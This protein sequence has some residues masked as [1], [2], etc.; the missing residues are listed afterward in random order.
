MAL[1]RDGI[2]KSCGIQDDEGLQVAENS[3]CRHLSWGA[4]HFLWVRVVLRLKHSM[5]E[6]PTVSRVAGERLDSW[7]EISAYL[8]RDPRTLQRWEKN[9]D[10]PVHRHVHDSQVSVYAY[11]HELDAWLASRTVSN[12]KGVPSQTWYARPRNWAVATAVAALV[13]A[14]FSIL[15]T[16]P[17]PVPRAGRAFRQLQ[18]NAEVDYTSSVSPDGRYLSFTDHR[19]GALG[20]RDLVSGTNR[21][22]SRKASDPSYSAFDAVFSPDGKSIIYSWIAASRPWEVH[23][24]NLDGTGERIVTK[25]RGKVQLLDWS[26]DGKYVAIIADQQLGLMSTSNGAIRI[27]KRLGA[28]AVQRAA[29]SRDGTYLVYDAPSAMRSDSDIFL[30]S[31]DGR[32]DR[33]LIQTPANEFMVGWDPKGDHIVFG[34]DR[35]GTAGIWRT[36]FRNGRTQGEPELLQ[37]DVGRVLPISVTQSGSVMLLRF[38]E[39]ADV[40][41]SQIGSSEAPKPLPGDVIGLRSS[42]SYSPDGRKLLYESSRDRTVRVRALDSNAEQTI[43]PKLKFFQKPRWAGGGKAIEISGTDGR[44]Q[45]SWRVADTGEVTL[46]EAGRPKPVYTPSEGQLGPGDATPSPDKS[47]VAVA[48]RGYPKAYNSLLLVPS[49][50]GDP[51]ELVRIKQP[52]RFTASFAWSPD[53]NFLYF[54]RH[55]DAGTE[56]MRISVRGGPPEPI[57]L[58]MPMIRNLSIHPDG[59]HIVFEAGESNATE[60][61]A[62]DGFLSQ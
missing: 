34:S 51:R 22:L 54:A 8:K 50:G 11:R 19:S 16:R 1:P 30:L 61:W 25:Q 10:L 37:E 35:T 17:A 4:G 47:L 57:G 15:R 48:V 45:G 52:D 26:V 13:V 58:R 59:K 55:S 2:A 24:V 46:L 32:E 49:H 29:F 7:K 62:L 31:V 18:A 20:I 33:P 56:V 21:L 60:L 3:L 36:G 23:Q 12:G 41:F 14:T 9:E 6:G 28:I 39:V 40:Y 44:T 5:A 43:Y 27:V 38:S 42:P 53:G